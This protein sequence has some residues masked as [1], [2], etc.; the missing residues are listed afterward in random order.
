MPYQW[1]EPEV[2]FEI[3]GVVV[4]HTYSGEFG[5]NVQD[6]W[7]T[8]EPTD[9]DEDGVG[10][11]QF[12][13]RDLK[14]ELGKPDYGE[15][16]IGASNHKELIERAIHLGLLKLPEWQVRKLRK[17]LDH[18]YCPACHV[19]H[20]TD[21][22]HFSFRDTVREYCHCANP[23]CGAVWANIYQFEKTETIVESQHEPA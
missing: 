20:K 4:Y 16:F 9:S 5:E 2:A 7:Y 22:D 11:Y 18:H 21:I 8:T 14:R 3:S 12:D 1:V 13:V 19:R 10:V 15:R 6:H 23:D 17:G